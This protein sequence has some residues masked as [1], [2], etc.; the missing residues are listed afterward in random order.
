MSAVFDSVGCFVV[1]D[2]R[3][4]FVADFIRKRGGSVIHLSGPDAAEVNPQISEAGVSVLPDDL[5][6]TND[7]GLQELYG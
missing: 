5:V 6:L 4:V 3:F 7:R 2:V 1:S